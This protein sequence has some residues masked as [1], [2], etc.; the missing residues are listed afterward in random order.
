MIKLLKDEIKK[1]FIK[2]G[3]KDELV[4]DRFPDISDRIDYLNK[5][6]DKQVE[7]KEFVGKI[8][9]VF[10]GLKGERGEKGEKGEKGEDGERGYTPKLG[11]D[12]FTDSEIKHIRATVE[13]KIKKPDPQI[14]KQTI[15]KRE[16]VSE[17]HLRGLVT[18][19]L[20]NFDFGITGEAIKREL[21]GLK[22]D[23]RLDAKAIKNLPKDIKYIALGGGGDGTVGGST[24]AANVSVDTTGFEVTTGVSNLQELAQV[25]DQAL[26]DTRSTGVRNGGG[27]TDLGS[28]VIRIAGGVGGIL[29]NTDPEDPDYN[30]VSWSQADLDLS[31]SDDVYYIYVDSTGTVGSTTTEPSHTDY[32]LY[33]WLHRVSIRGGAYSASTPIVMPVQQ[34]G[35]GIWD[36]FRAYGLVKKGLDVSAASNNLTIAVNE[37]EIYQTGANFYE[38][39]TSP[40]EVTY[41]IKSP[42]T[43]RHVDQDGDQSGD[44]TILDV[45]NYDNGGTITAIPGSSSRTQIFTIYQFPG[46]GGNIRVFYGQAFYNNIAE[47][48]QALGT[49]APVTPEGYDAAIVIGYIIATKGATDLSDGAQAI[50]ITTNKFGGIGGGTALSFGTGLT[51]GDKGDI[52]VS[53]A[54]TVWTIDNG[55][56]TYDKIQNVSANSVLAN[57]TAST[58]SVAEVSLSASQLLGRGSTGDIAAIT[59]GTNLSMSG[60][61]LN[62][63]GGG[64]PAGSSGQ[65]Q[66]NNGGSFGGAAGVTYQAG[67]SPNLTVQAQNAAHIPLA[68]KAASSHSTYIFTAQSSGGVN[69]FKVHQTGALIIGATDPGT[70]AAGDIFTRGTL[71][72]GNASVSPA[73]NAIFDVVDQ[74]NPGTSWRGMRFLVNVTPTANMTG[75]SAIEATARDVSFVTNNIGSMTAINTTVSLN[76]S[77]STTNMI[78][79]STNTG[80]GSSGGTVNSMIGIALY[81]SQSSGSINFRYGIRYTQLTGS[82]IS[83]TNEYGIY[84]DDV[85]QGSSAAFAIVTNAGNIVFNEGGDAN[86]VFRVEGDTDQNLIYTAPS[87]DRVGIGTPTPTAKLDVN[88]DVFRLR[89]AKTPASAAATG[90]QGDVAWDTNYVY[91]CVATNTWKRS[92][93]ATW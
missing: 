9:N 37:G 5:S 82:A 32:R 70:I 21:E 72:I 6:F 2:R 22:G 86:T 26:L 84:L 78:G 60:T 74:R 13:S 83:V 63:T 91:V 66:Y 73:S 76:G 55:A 7:D 49:Y 28:G 17:D 19:I 45:A 59:L 67:A 69:L 36:V 1:E 89:T 14:V 15:V 23:S 8:E 90:N 31:A 47:A 77:G 71:S 64:T 57:N 35:P 88:S 3:L 18:S 29:D 44:T 10:K 48:E 51:D 30:A 79:I 58:A 34:Y 56:V 42:A 61:T 46:S 25:T 93:I 41:P 11:K 12:Y 39:P 75:L 53:G 27:L 33:I 62:A 38:D 68:A 65:L 43:F 87:T 24:T 81:G 50:F 20:E 52:T 40:H 92:A 54:G 80:I 4:I 16:Q 85:N